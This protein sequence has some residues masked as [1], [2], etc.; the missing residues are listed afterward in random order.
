MTPARRPYAGRLITAFGM[1]STLVW[2]VR[3]WPRRRGPSP[4]RRRRGDAQRL[5]G[6]DR[7]AMVA[8]ELRTPVGAIRHAALAL[9]A[10]GDARPQVRA[11]CAIIRRQSERVGRLVDDLLLPPGA[12]AE[13]LGLGLEPLDLA[14]VLTETVEAL[15]GLV[16]ERGHQLQ[17]TVPP[18]SLV[19][20]GDAD[21]LAQVVTNLV[22]NAAKFTPAGGHVGV[23]LAR[24]GDEAVVCVRDSGI[25]IAPAMQDRIFRLFT[26]AAPSA[27]VGRGIGLSVV[28]LIIA[29]HG[30]RVT[31]HSDG[32]GRGSEFVVRLPGPVSAALGVDAGDPRA[33]DLAYTDQACQQRSRLTQA[34][35]G[36]PGIGPALRAGPEEAPTAG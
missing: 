4:E 6:N 23:T 9:E 17:L 2:A 32:P 10:A 3:R 28:E 34:G 13:T 30:G 20:R 15:R 27:D 29:R 11:A 33:G 18:G 1:L 7:L 12:R 8:H 26:R 5:L 25:G 21:R 22:W 24:E 19:I 35:V 36:A 31:V 16:E 14:A